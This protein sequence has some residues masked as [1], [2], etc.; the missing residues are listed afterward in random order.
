MITA[1]DKRLLDWV[2]E[3][4][5]SHDVSDETAA[6][7][8]VSVKTA[9]KWADET[10]MVSTMGDRKLNAALAAMQE[11][12]R[13]PDYMR[14]IK[15]AVCAIWRDAADAGLCEHPRKIR[16]IRARI[17]RPEIWTPQEIAK[18]VAGA[19]KLTGQFRTLELSRPHYWKTLISVAWDTGLRRRDLHQL[20]TR[21][22]KPEFVWSQ[23]K[24]AKSVKVRLRDST[25]QLVKAWHRDETG[26]LWPMWASDN[27]FRMDW[28]RIVG[29][30][31][32]PYG[33]FKRIRKSAGTA[34][35]EVTPGAGH[36][37]L[38]N[39]RAIFERHY[40]D[41]M[42]IETPQPPELRL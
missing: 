28:Y 38:G 30:A 20:T 35:E 16:S 26:P 32:V 19:G 33:P 2:D 4:E 39:T 22:L 34:A 7:Y 36:Y 27:A 23:H 11:A 1:D 41:P 14:S 15:S 29:L 24:T 6:M 12:G 3:Y 10:F 37:L 21:D 8:R 5:L 13:S 17:Q 31:A 18:L 40:L 42:R 25:L 9:E